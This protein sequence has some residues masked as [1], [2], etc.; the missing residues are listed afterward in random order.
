[1]AL[2]RAQEKAGSASRMQM[3]SPMQMSSRAGTFQR[4]RSTSAS[5]PAP[6][7]GWNDRDSLADMKEDD[8][9]T[10][11][12]LF[13]STTSVNARDGYSRFS[14][15]YPAVVETLIAYSGAATD[16]LKAI[17]NGGVYDATAGGAIGAAELSGLTNSRWQYINVATPGGNF[18]EMCNGADNVYTYDGTTWTDQGGN[19]SGVTSSNL[20]NINLFKNRVWFIEENTLKAWYLPVQSIAGAANALD[21][22][23][24]APHGGYLM[25]MGTWTI[26]AGYGVD[27]LAVFITSNGDVLVYRGTD[28]SSASTW[29]LV[30]VWW[31]GSPVGRR[32]FVKY[33]G[34]LVI[35]TQEGL[36][37]MSSLLQS[38]QVN[39]R[40][41]L[42]DKIQK[43]MAD[44]V[45]NYGSNFGWQVIPFDPLNMLVLNVPVTAGASQQQYVMNSITGAWCNFTGW[46]ANCFEILGDDLYFGGTNYV[47][48]AFDTAEDDG[49]AIFIDGLQAFNYFGS[50]GQLKRFTMLRP[51]LLINSTQQ[52]NINMNVDF[53]QT[54][55]ASAIGTAAFSGAVWDTAQWDNA[56]W[57]STL[58]VSAIW[59]GSTGV[60]YCGAPHM[61]ANLDGASLQWVSTDVVMEP[62]GIL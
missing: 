25:A 14:T 7:G 38:S 46:N 42:T 5:L 28:P 27:D 31:I 62:G 40:V 54:A 8:A 22:S 2:R 6:V 13:P 20:I 61:Q 23:S 12:N 4:N 43:T 45:T 18:I 19:I 10:L 49:G 56:Q 39:P 53:D 3:R 55:P 36:V 1:M 9:V 21:L 17:S 35:I 37:A 33:R 41:A 51:M 34:D 16:K 29:A 26:D 57:S 58:S 52:V 48:K 50:R 44:A 24:F 47:A 15:G 59:Q 30:G 60:G 32:C 11:V